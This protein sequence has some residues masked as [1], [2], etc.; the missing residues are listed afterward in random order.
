[1]AVENKF[2]INVIAASVLMGLSLSAVAAGGTD[3][4]GKTEKGAVTAEKEATPA[5]AKSLAEVVGTAKPED[6]SVTVGTSGSIKLDAA[7]KAVDGAGGKPAEDTV[8]KRRWVTPGTAKGSLLS[9]M[10][11][12]RPVPLTVSIMPC[13]TV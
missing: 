8:W 7:L 3:N 2:K 1:M 12:L 6:I 11:V 13:P 5:K 4:A 9:R 10:S